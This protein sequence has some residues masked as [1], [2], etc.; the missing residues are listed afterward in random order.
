MDTQVVGWGE[1]QHGENSDVCSKVV[2]MPVPVHQGRVGLTLVYHNS[3]PTGSTNTTT[4]TTTTVSQSQNTSHIYQKKGILES[5][6]SER[7]N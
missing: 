1:N 5:R 4:T 2:S 3:Y 6:K 7:K